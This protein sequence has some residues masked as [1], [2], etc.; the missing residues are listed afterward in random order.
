MVDS[1]KPLE[2]MGLL[3]K[4]GDLTIASDEACLIFK[5]AGVVTIVPSVSTPGAIIG[6]HVILA[7]TITKLLAGDDERFDAVIAETMQEIIRSSC[8]PARPM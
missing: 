8:T 1:M 2:D 4:T 7:L 6:K 5:S 3:D